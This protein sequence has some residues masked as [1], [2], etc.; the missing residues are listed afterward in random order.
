MRAVV[1]RVSQ[2]SVTV[3]GEV[4]GEIDGPGPGRAARRHPRRR[5]RAD[6]A[7]LARK[8]WELRILA[9]EKSASDLGAPRARRQP[10]HAVR[11]HPQGPPPVLVGGRT[12]AVSE[13]LYEAFCAALSELGAQVETGVFGAHMDV[14]LVNDGPSRSCSTR[15]LSLRRHEPEAA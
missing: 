6:A 4:V 9:D 5:R 8:I 15:T 13:P 11:R 12:G 14:A 7:A 1:Q 10:V 3:D 2:A